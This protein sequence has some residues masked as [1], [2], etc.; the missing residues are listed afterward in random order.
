MYFASLRLRG[1]DY[2]QVYKNKHIKMY[3]CDLLTWQYVY[4]TYLIKT[5]Q[6]KLLESLNNYTEI[7]NQLL[8]TYLQ[9]Q[10]KITLID[11]GSEGIAYLFFWFI[12][13]FIAFVMISMLSKILW[14][15]WL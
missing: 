8:P 6:I 7:C 14:Q 13:I 10:T 4:E 2:G 3:P 11:L 1:S 12:V 5:P 9:G 15:I